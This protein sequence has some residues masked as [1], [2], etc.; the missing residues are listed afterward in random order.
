PLLHGRLGLVEVHR[1]LP[2]VVAPAASRARGA[3]RDRATFG[4]LA[5]AALLVRC[6][7]LGD[8]AWLPSP[9]LLVAHSLAPALGQHGFRPGAYPPLRLLGDLLDI[10]VASAAGERLL[11][12]AR[13]LVAP[14]VTAAEVDGTVAATRALAAGALP[15]LE[16][17]SAAS[18]M[19]RHFLAGALD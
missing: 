17:P 4:E 14:M 10:G 15:D 11:A 6:D 18:R 2:A 19:L 16:G 5:D 7:E 8:G 3:S 13:P 9:P 12:T 1:Y